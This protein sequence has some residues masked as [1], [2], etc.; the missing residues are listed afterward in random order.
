MEIK[1]RIETLG[2]IVADLMV[3]GEKI[4]VGHSSFYGDKFQE[5]LNNFFFIYEIVKTNNKDYFPY[6]FET[7][8]N[9]DFVNH[10]W[11][12][13]ID[14]PQSFIKINLFELS[15]SNAEYKV[16]LVSEIIKMEDLFDSIYLSLEEAFVEFGFVGYKKNWEIGNF[17]IYEYITL[18]SE[19]E[20]IKLKSSN[21]VDEEWKQKINIDD[22]LKIIKI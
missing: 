16:E 4:K 17:P 9:D 1:F 7:L 3:S 11:T 14:S 19:K 12:V 13:G 6:S 5:L 22:E 15:P 2:Y 21:E 8:W 10:L 20:G 18:K